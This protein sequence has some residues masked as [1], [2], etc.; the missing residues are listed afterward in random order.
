MEKSTNAVER[1]DQPILASVNGGP[2]ASDKDENILRPRSALYRVR[3]I[4][5]KKTYKD[6]ET[7]QLIP[8]IVEI[9]ATGRSV[10][11][12]LLDKVTRI[13]RSEASLSN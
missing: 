7:L 12:G 9:S 11:G 10:A 3:L 13:F 8:G 4:A 5:S 1:I 6:G 2:I